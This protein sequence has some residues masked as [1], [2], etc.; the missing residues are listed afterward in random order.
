MATDRTQLNPSSISDFHPVSRL[1][2]Q[3][4]FFDVPLGYANH[5]MASPLARFAI[6][7]ARRSTSLLRV[8]NASQK[9]VSATDS[10]W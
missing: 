2:S 9:P 1:K 6:N 7:G 4:Y 3:A 5:T 10:R 8:T